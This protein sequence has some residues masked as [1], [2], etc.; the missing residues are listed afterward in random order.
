MMVLVS[1]DVSTSDPGGERRLRRV[2]KA[3]RD[4]GQRVQYSVFEIELDPAQWTMLKQ[5]L[6]DLIDPSRDSLR[7]YHLGKNW[8]HRVEHVGAKAA[9]DLNGPLIF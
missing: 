2:A 5:T 1:Y 6:T 9:L 4:H 8:Q 3:C 7:F